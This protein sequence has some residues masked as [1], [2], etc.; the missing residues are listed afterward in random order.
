ME[1]M[2]LSKFTSTPDI[3]KGQKRNTNTHFLVTENRNTYGK[4]N[5]SNIGVSTGTDV[6]TSLV[7]KNYAFWCKRN[8]FL[9]HGDP[10]REHVQFV[11]FFVH[12]LT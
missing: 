4:N 7:A 6:T 3:F 8:P 11:L 10:F 5:F 9:T 2:E 12:L 1:F